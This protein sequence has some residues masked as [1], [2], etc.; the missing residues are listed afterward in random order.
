MHENHIFPFLW[1]RG[2]EEQVLRTELEKIYE[3]EDFHEMQR[4]MYD[5]WFEI[6]ILTQNYYI[7]KEK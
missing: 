5:D 7:E 4:T 2:E 3:A 1:M 6:P